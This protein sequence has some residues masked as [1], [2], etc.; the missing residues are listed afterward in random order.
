MNAVTLVTCA[1]NILMNFVFKLTR[2]SSK[3]LHD[4]KVVLIY[5]IRTIE[6]GIFGEERY[7]TD[8]A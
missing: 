6:K 1:D 4:A 3:N 2:Y 8:L 7:W 5:A